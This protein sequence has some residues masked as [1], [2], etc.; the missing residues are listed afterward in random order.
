MRAI[1]KYIVVEPI[2][3]ETTAASG[4]I[5][6]S[7]DENELRYGKARVV[8]VGGDVIADVAESSVIYYDRRAGH[9]VRIHR[10]PYHIIQ[11]RDVV[12]VLDSQ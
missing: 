11:E 1:G 8:Y 6:T 5:M 9:G 7:T 3:E 12:L 2:K 10:L 4:L